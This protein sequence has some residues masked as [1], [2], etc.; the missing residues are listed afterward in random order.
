MLPLVQFRLVRAFPGV[1]LGH[2]FEVQ[3]IIGR[4]RRWCVC[5]YFKAFVRLAH[6]LQQHEIR[7]GHDLAPVREGQDSFVVLPAPGTAC[8]GTAAARR[9][10]FDAERRAHETGSR[11]PPHPSSSIHGLLH[12]HTRA[13]DR[14]TM[15]GEEA[16]RGPVAGELRGDTPDT[17]QKN[18]VVRFLRRLT[19]RQH[20]VRLPAALRFFELDR[21]AGKCL[22]VLWQAT[23]RALRCGALPF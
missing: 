15:G 14:S 5:R 17:Q 16:T 13:M 9:D 19:K 22:G 18:A 11:P 6:E 20:L 7:C 12:A 21:R 8:P 3:V 10:T 23:G 2:S 4:H 1:H